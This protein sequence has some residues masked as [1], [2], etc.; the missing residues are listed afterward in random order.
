[1]TSHEI[2]NISFRTTT[3]TPL[4]KL[5]N[6]VGGA[7]WNMQVEIAAQLAEYNEREDRRERAMLAGMAMQGI[8]AGYWSNTE[9]SGLNPAAIAME[10]ANQ[11]D[12]L[13]VELARKK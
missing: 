13:L 11:A 7:L 3:S 1:M 5:I 2:R 12:A 6:D 4:E 8:L 10:A 9:T